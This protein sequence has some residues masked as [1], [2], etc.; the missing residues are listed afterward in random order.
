MKGLIFL[1]ERIK[2][3][4]L[5]LP[6]AIAFFCGDII[7]SIVA[8]ALG[9]MAF[10]EFKEAFKNKNINLS[11]IPAGIL[12]IFLILVI[13]QLVSINF[14]FICV[15]LFFFLAFL[16]IL[17]KQNI[18]ETA[19][20]VLGLFY[21]FIPFF[22]VSQIYNKSIYWA[23]FVLV[24]SFSTDI[25]AY[26]SGRLFG[27]HKLIPSISPKKTIEGSIGGI[28]C[29]VLVSILYSKI[30]GIY[31]NNILLIGLFGS[32]VAQLGDLFASAIKRY[33]GIK[34][35]GKLIPGHGGILDRFDS[36]IFVSLLVN[37]FI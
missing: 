24:I 34:D 36:V 2:G 20:N 26:F 27:K 23:I 28:I 7:F 1:L 35:F 8:I 14:L 22:L 11:L 5:L 16:L 4:L 18:L 3:A 37:L 13:L 33:C 30:T 31:T 9:L 25:F 10:W 12:T 29:T 32:I 21:C 15:L 17:E 6:L 19:T